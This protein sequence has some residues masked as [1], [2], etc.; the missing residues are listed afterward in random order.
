VYD[1]GGGAATVCQLNGEPR[2]V[3]DRCFGPTSGPNWSD[4]VMSNGGWNSRSTGVS[5]YTVRDGDLEGWT[6]SNGFGS[7]PPATTFA[8]ACATAASAPARSATTPRAAAPRA[9]VSPSASQVSA[10]VPSPTSL[11]SVLPDTAAS[12]TPLAA[13]PGPAGDTAA[14]LVFGA[15]AL[16]LLGLAGWSLLR[17]AP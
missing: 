2:Q 8:H 13:R 7:P 15:S 6:Y 3:P 5:G 9:T 14:Y 12:A 16:L 17:R 4:W 10:A 1:W 11:A